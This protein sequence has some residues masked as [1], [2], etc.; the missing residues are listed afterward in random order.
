MKK[1]NP[2]GSYSQYIIFHLNHDGNW[3]LEKLE[4]LRAA[5][6]IIAKEGFR[7]KR[8]QAIIVL[9]DLKKVPYALFADTED[10]LIPVSSNE[11]HGYKKL[12]V[13]WRKNT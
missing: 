9:K 13:N 7:R 1:R 3:R 8:T 4:N 6:Y 12:L 2:A 5:Q 11:A 10:G